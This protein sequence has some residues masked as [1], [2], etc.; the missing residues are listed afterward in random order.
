MKLFAIFLKTVLEAAII[1]E[2]ISILNDKTPIPNLSDRPPIAAGTRNPPRAPK[3]EM[4][5][6]TKPVLNGKEEV[7]KAIIEG[8]SPERHRPISIILATVHKG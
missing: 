3:T 1:T 8:Y 5:A 2:R 4:K 7:A 6:A